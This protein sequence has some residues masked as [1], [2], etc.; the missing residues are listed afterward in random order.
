MRIGVLFLAFAVLAAC[1]GGGKSDS[2]KALDVARQW[3]N[4]STDLVAEEIVEFVIG[5]IPLVSGLASE[6]LEDQIHKQLTWQF[7]EP[8][9]ASGSMYS[10]TAT[11]LVS[12]EFSLPLLGTQAY[13][14]SLPFDLTIDVD[15]EEVTRYSTDLLGASIEE[16]Q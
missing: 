13:A 2:E 4:D 11:C 6:L 16:Q 14:I 8:A 15:K 7:S 3:V 5:E 12:L 9:K 1:G 10:V